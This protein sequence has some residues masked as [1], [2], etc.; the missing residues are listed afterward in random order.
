MI[1][2][3]IDIKLT[4]QPTTKEGCNWMTLCAN[5]YVA[6]GAQKLLKSRNVPALKFY[7]KESLH[8][9]SIFTEQMTDKISEIEINIQSKKMLT[10]IKA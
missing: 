9:I 5:I 8:S 2:L 3:L 6:H 10:K 4:K 1:L 7:A